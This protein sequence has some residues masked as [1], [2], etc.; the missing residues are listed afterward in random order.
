SRDVERI[1]ERQRE[2]GGRFGDAGK[3]LGLVEQRDIDFAL[4]RQFDYP[5]LRSGESRVSQ[6]VVAAYE[7]ASPQ[8]EAL[9]ALR[10]E[11]MLHWF[12]EDAA[13]KSV[14][15]VSEARGE[16][17]SH[18]AAN[19]AVVLSQLGGRTLLIDADLRKP[20]QHALFGLENRVGLS[21]VLAGRAGAEAVQRVAE[22]G[23]LSV[24]PAGVAPPNPQELL[25]RPT[26]GVLLERLAEHVDFIL[27]DTPPAAESA[28]A[29]TVAARARAALFVVRKNH[30][31]LWRV[32]AIAE[33]LARTR[34]AVLGA[35]L[36]DF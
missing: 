1:L 4:S 6:S 13:H 33:G 23:N 20:S 3:A 21:A 17:R 2:Q 7:P 11:L 29:Q 16:G 34:A 19:L 15:I 25:A 27:I 31:R 5:Y 30:S 12:N 35:V 10:S 32:Q 14:A 18:I 24:L 8:V 36:N 22:L 26:F 9:R 28:D